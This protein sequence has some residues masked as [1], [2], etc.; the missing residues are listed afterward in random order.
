MG[1]AQYIAEQKRPTPVYIHM[2]HPEVMRMMMT[3]D[4]R[5]LILAP[6]GQ[7]IMHVLKLDVGQALTDWNREDHL[8]NSY[9]RQAGIRIDHVPQP[10]IALLRYWTG[11][12]FDEPSV[13]TYDYLIAPWSKDSART[14]TVVEFAALCDILDGSVGILG[15]AHDVRP[16]P[17][18][19]YEY[20]RP[21]TDVVAMM[22]AARKAVIT[23]DSGMN[24]LAHAA[25]ISNHVILHPNYL[26]EHW[27]TYPGAILVH[28]PWSPGRVRTA[29][30]ERPDA[31]R[32]AI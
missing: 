29:L 6:G 25:N 21:L 20:G 23:V 10:K 24:R 17:A 4:M 30:Q 18:L 5:E 3:G 28:A 22:R 11:S 26:P 32:C 1:A 14:M 19:R 31:L 7:Q 2:A 9:L 15:S 8:I 16:Y 12:G 13:P 27:V